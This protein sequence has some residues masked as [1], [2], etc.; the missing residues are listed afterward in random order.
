M[1][2]FAQVSL[3]SKRFS[4]ETSYNPNCESDLEPLTSLLWASVSPFSKEAFISIGPP[5]KVL[6]VTIWG[7]L[8]QFLVK[9][10]RAHQMEPTCN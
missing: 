9:I 1:G 8:I 7:S 10:F 2:G 3:Q 5:L 6:E 4:D